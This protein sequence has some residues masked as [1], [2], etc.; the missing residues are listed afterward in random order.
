MTQSTG[1]H[2]RSR[3]ALW[4]ALGI[5]G[6]VFVWHI[7]SSHSYA[8]RLDLPAEIQ[9]ISD[10]EINPILNIVTVT[11]HDD[12]EAQYGALR[13]G[14]LSLGLDAIE[15][16]L[17]IAARESMDFW[18]TLLPW[19]V[20]FRLGSAGYGRTSMT[21]VSPTALP[22]S[23]PNQIV[24][25]PSSPSGSEVQVDPNVA[26]DAMPAASAVIETSQPRDPWL[27][28]GL[29]A[30]DG[31]LEISVKN[32]SIRHVELVSFG[33]AGF[34]DEKYLVVA[35]EYRNRSKDM[36]LDFAT[37]RPHIGDMMDTKAVLVDDVGN[38]YKLIDVGFSKLVG[39]PA[40]RASI[41]PEQSIADIVVFEPPVAAAKEFRLTL[42]G[43]FESSVK[44]R[45]MLPK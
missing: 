19:R 15:S 21:S 20:K 8:Y 44:L 11:V 28:A 13:T 31:L 45:F 39:V 23:S 17:D 37:A 7:I 24:D 30:S 38:R 9:E 36:K 1:N 10:I 33:N 3:T 25:L 6:P 14:L 22:P 29:V 32:A 16:R 5:T 27:D 40:D 12:F 43:Q 34:S 26:A 41:Y 2:V 42:P 18:P 4:I 35:L